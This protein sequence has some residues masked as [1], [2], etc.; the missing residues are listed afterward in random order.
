M[1]ETDSSV[2]TC[3]DKGYFEVFQRSHIVDAFQVNRSQW[4]N[5]TS[6]LNQNKNRLCLNQ[7]IR[8]HNW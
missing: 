3:E 4:N 7:E 6:N 8:T 5:K 1:V 2:K